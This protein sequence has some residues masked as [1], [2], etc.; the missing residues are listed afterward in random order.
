MALSLSVL[1]GCSS[2]PTSSNDQ[3]S[4]SEASQPESSSEASEPESSSEASQPE[5]SSEASEPES[6]SEASQ[7]AG[8]AAEG[9]VTID[10]VSFVPPEEFAAVEG[11]GN[12]WLA[13]DYPT[14]GSNVNVSVSAKDPT[15]TSQTA[16]SEMFEELM[17]QQFQSQYQMEVDVTM[18]E[19]EYITVDDTP[20]ARIA[21]SYSLAGI[22][23]R[24]LMITVDADQTYTFAYTQTG[25]A[26]WW[27]A[28]EASVKTIQVAD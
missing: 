15:F 4:S 16:T 17:E 12:M 28:F 18:D 13:P 24:Q 14:D 8:D 23:I 3:S 21:V 10:S 2:E 19:F 22:S 5:S 20:A 1:A 27:D 7:P 26:G 6:S 25:E 9:T 11:S